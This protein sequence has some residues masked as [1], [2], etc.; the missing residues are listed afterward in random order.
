[1][2]KR[3]RGVGTAG[4]QQENWGKIRAIMRESWYEDR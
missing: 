1:M 2:E 4:K 3:D